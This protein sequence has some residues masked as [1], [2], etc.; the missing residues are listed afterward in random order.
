MSN[1]K[2]IVNEPYELKDEEVEIID[3]GEP[4]NK[5]LNGAGESFEESEVHIEAFEDEE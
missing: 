1:E 2:E 4:E 3:A 5:K